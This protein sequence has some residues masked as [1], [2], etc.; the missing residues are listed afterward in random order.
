MGFIYGL[1]SHIEIVGVGDINA[2]ETL[3]ER[4]VWAHRHW[5]LVGEDASSQRYDFEEDAEEQA[6][7]SM[8]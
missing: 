8:V 4:I 2:K 7:D 5:T 6:G 3:I 1:P